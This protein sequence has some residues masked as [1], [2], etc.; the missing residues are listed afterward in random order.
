MNKLETV[1]KSK[2]CSLEEDYFKQI[3]LRLDQ[4]NKAEP[5]GFTL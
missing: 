4:E 1:R 5:Y 3:K 2:P